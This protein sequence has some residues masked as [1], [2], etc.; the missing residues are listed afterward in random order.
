MTRHPA[1][2]V[3]AGW[4]LLNGILCALLVVY[5]ESSFTVALYGSVV[6]L[7]EAAALA[8]LAS[9]V[10]GAEEHT[11]YRRPPGGGAPVLLLAAAAGVTGLAFVF[12][13]WLLAIAVPLLA[14]AAALGLRYSWTKGGSV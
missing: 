13:F 9:S 2:A 11:C 3:V 5:G 10:S 6:A 8:A 7:I 12:S 1:F 4:G 14:A